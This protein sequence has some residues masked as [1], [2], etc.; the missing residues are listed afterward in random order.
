MK[1]LKPGFEF[2]DERGIFKEI[3]RGDGWRELNL[4]GR[5]KGVNSGNHYHK[6]TRELFYVIEGSGRLTIEHARTGKIKVYP[7]KTNDIF[8]VEPFEKH[9]FVYE[10]NTSFAILLSKPHNKR[11]PDIF[12]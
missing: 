12:L 11:R 6:R 7:F 2:E 8:I 1:F 3:I 5:W 4:A 10:E 9:N